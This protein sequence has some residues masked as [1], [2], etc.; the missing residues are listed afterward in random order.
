M[1]HT[2]QIDL[3]NKNSW[4]TLQTVHSTESADDD[5]RLS[6]WSLASKSR[7]QKLKLVKVHWPFKLEKIFDTNEM[8]TFIT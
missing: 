1:I 7:S 2:I 3:Y 8:W 6:D 5:H 4:M